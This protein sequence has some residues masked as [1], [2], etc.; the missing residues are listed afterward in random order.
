VS[1]R[2]LVVVSDPDDLPEL[3]DRVAGADSYLATDASTA[4][5]LTVV[6]LCRSYRYRSKG[7]YVSLVAD[8]RGHRVLPA[9]ETL[10]ELA[11]PFGIFRVLRE[12]GIPTL[13]VPEL[14]SWRAPEES[15]ST[16]ALATVV[17]GD[18]D[19]PRF[20]Q[21]ARAAYRAWPVPVLRLSFARRG[22][23]WWVA[24][25]EAVPLRRMRPGE[26][27]K[28]VGVLASDAPGAVGGAARPVETKRASIAV[29]FDEEDPFSPST[30]ETIDHLE[31]LAAGMNVYV[32]RI[33]LDQIESLAEYDALFIRAITGVREP[34]FQFALRAEMLDM[35]VLDDTQSIIRCSNKV[36]L[37][38]LL[39]REGIPTPRT[40]IVS[41]RT[42]WAEVATLGT[43]L[44]VKLP[45]GSFS[46]A[47]HRV[48]GEAEYARVTAEMFRRSPLL[49]AQEFLQTDFDWRVT[50]L[51]GQVL[52]TARYFMAEGHW[53]IRSDQA[54]GEEEFGDVEAVARDRAPRE[55]V[56]LAR[57]AAALIGQGLYGVD[58]KEGPGGPVVIEIN[59]NPNLDRG[60]ED[61][62]DGD[63]VYRDI[64]TYFLRRVEERPDV[65]ELARRPKRGKPHY[66]P[67]SVAG[68]ELEYAVVDAETLDPRS[69]VEDAF[70][71]IAGRPVSEV[72]LGGVAFSN[73]IADHVFEIKTPL[74]TRSLARAEE[75]LV[76]G[77]RRF[78]DVLEGEFGARLLPTG[79]HPWL[80]PARAR[81]WR[82][83]GRRI[84]DAYARVFD[85]HT[86]GWM[87]VHAAHLNLP[88]GRGPE[89]VAMYNATAL[90]IPYLPA[91][92][93]SSPMFDG[94]LHDP[95]DNRMEWIFRHQAEIPE[96]QGEI[97]PE[98]IV[99]VSD[100]RRR[101]LQPMYR[102]LEGRPGTAVLKHD[103]FNARGAVLKFSRRALE[104]RVLDMQECV[105][106][107]IAIAVYVRAILR[108]YTRR[109]L[110]G[111]M[112]VPPPQILL[113]D[114][115]ATIRSG[116]EARV[117]APQLGDALERDGDGR[118]S[119]RDCLR[120]LL[121]IAEKSVRRDEAEYLPLVARVI[122]EGPL[123]ERIRA[124]LLPYSDDDGRL[125]RAA[126]AVYG[127]LADSL[128]RN[129]PWPGRSATAAVE[130]GNAPG[131]TRVRRAA[132]R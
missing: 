30:S 127:E 62:A 94:S 108:H 83:S 57:R 77:V 80:D 42:P 90:L 71:F 13:P 116:S 35:P 34:S 98:S 79:M 125:R 64:L 24:G 66:R 61:R 132:G 130:A 120:S 1:A 38:E 95:V 65:P 76:D 112:T 17:F 109:V 88:M 107:D 27:E 40:M 10:E 75:L 52:F 39:R 86:H 50:L 7:Y 115:R 26:R 73:E 126:A 45:D 111:R 81:L 43:P 5:A 89:A 53:Q 59:D 128:V 110:T 6:N 106:L 46:S 28:L 100:Y 37:E 15:T 117:V 68:I 103:F 119:V 44:V 49:I 9:I 104:I 113:A 58:I 60:E 18:C 101:I 131:E 14:R 36:F 41:S 2:V 84:Y 55:V 31:R 69:L 87:N 51:D 99:S 105:K 129:V 82:R 70:R 21:A 122:E 8:A 124:A 123:S 29:L 19:D 22:E 48:S 91:L 102:A 32:H 78:S 114:F 92:A 93:A 11:E 23:Q 121:A 56:E 67:F 63:T 33:G 54:Q 3:G 16:S 25:A 72:D 118:A 12:A 20:E 85:V 97:L 47:V 96:S 74:P 4:G